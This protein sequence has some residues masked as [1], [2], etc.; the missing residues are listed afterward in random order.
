MHIHQYLQRGRE[1]GRLKVQPDVWQ[2]RLVA[3]AELEKLGWRGLRPAPVKNIS[4]RPPVILAV[5]FSL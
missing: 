4:P 5:W 3:T 1:S 2:Q